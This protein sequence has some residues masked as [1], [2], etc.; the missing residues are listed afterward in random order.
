MD[1]LE[2]FYNSA[3]ANEMAREYEEQCLRQ[4]SAKELDDCKRASNTNNASS[5]A[6][7]VIG[8]KVRGS[9]S[10]VL[11][12]ILSTL[13]QLRSDYVLLGN[14]MM[15]LWKNTAQ[16]SSETVMQGIT[17]VRDLLQ[18]L[19]VGECVGSSEKCIPTLPFL[20]PGVIVLRKRL[21]K[22][23]IQLMEHLNTAS[24]L[25]ASQQQCEVII[26][27]GIQGTQRLGRVIS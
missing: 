22:C 1:L 20:K 4:F 23:E 16:E 17:A 15:S 27:L 5:W 6:R 12:D 10:A 25:V 14:S 3:R 11:Q 19:G 21:I 9:L 8:S 18:E 24:V 26:A 13:K 2:D 7:G